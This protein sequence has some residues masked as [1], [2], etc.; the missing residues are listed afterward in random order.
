MPETRRKRNGVATFTVVS[1]GAIGALLLLP[2]IVWIASSGAR[3][4]NVDARVA[5]EP[6]ERIQLNRIDQRPISVPLTIPNTSQWKQ[7]R[8]VWGEP[9]FVISAVDATGEFVRCLPEMPLRI[10]LIDATG[11]TIPLQPDNGAYGYSCRCQS[12]SLRF[13][14]RPGSQLTLKVSA[15]SRGTVLRG[16][17][18]VVSDWVNTKDKLAGLN[19]DKS[20]ETVV[21]WLSIPGFLFVA[22]GAGVFIVNGIR[23]YATK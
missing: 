8:K 16:D 20:I 21:T 6:L 10:E 12:G 22:C 9:G 7:I 19:L 5:F 17:L 1:L 14:A 23:H 13:N 4:N 11:N 18:I 3:L 2:G 15:T